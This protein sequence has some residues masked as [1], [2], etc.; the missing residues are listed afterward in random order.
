VPNWALGIKPAYY[1]GK[2]IKLK[3]Y[4]AVHMTLGGF[5]IKFYTGTSGM[6]YTHDSNV[7]MVG[8]SHN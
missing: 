5:F 6:D 1:K 7:Y 2:V 4:S 3:Y 8:S